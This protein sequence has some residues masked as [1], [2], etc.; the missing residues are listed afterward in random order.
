MNKEIPVKYNGE[1]VGYTTDEGKT[2]QFNDSD[3][4]KK[5]NE[6]L[7]QKQSIWGISSRAIGEIKSDNTVELNEIKSYDISHFGNKQ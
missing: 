2:I 4:S 6:M 7:N 3:A 5:V 1:I